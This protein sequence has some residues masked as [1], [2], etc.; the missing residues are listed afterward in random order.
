M[1]C[2]SPFPSAVVVPSSA[3]PFRTV[4]MA[5]AS[6]VPVSVGLASLVTPPDAI[7]TVSGGTLSAALAM[8]GAA[9]GAASMVTLAALLALPAASLAITL[10]TVPLA[11]GVA[12][13]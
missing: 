8:V 10:T 4:M 1:N 3:V 7:G 5:P 2:Q 6:A 12:G 9:G 13:V 11:I